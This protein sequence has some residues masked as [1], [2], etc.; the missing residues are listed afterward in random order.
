MREVTAVKPVWQAISAARLRRRLPLKF[1][2]S[3]A[4]LYA[5]SLIVFVLLLFAIAPGWFAKY[6]PTDMQADQLLLPPGS[7]HWLGT[8]YF[9]RDVLSLVI[10]G[11]RESLFIGFASVIVGGFIGAAVGMAAGYCGGWVDNVLMRINDIVMTVPSVLLALA[12]AAA[13]GPGLWNIVLAV[14]LSAVPNYAR[15]MRGQILSLRNRSF[16]TASRSLGAAP[17][18]LFLK[19]IVPNSI[20]PLLVMAA[21]GIGT[22]ILTGSGLSFL[23]LGVLKE[24]PD[25][26][27]LL[28]QGRG[29]LSVAWWICTFPGLAIT[30][31]VLSVNVLGD[32]LRDRLDPRKRIT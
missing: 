15:V 12:I 28:S 7:A 19:H 18:P 13:L 9:G 32:E 6:A 26:G 23:G 17:L 11:A 29:Y 20:S 5:A 1:V 22:A 24:V 30:L 31:F 21:I 8:D 10:Y 16:I 25:W 14:A 27:A 4:I 3:Q 2:P